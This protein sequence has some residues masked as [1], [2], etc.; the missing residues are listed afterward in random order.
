MGNTNGTG[1]SPGSALWPVTA[2]LLQSVLTVT[3]SLNVGL[4]W[5]T[6][7][8]PIKMNSH[9]NFAALLYGNVQLN[10]AVFL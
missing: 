2:L 1:K 4:H 7:F 3:S 10:A 8:L 5:K 6:V 9:S